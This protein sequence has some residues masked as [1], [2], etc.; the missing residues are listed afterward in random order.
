MGQEIIQH[1]R[2]EL[3]VGH[4]PRQVSRYMI[5]HLVAWPDAQ[6]LPDRRIDQE[7][8]VQRLRRDRQRSCLYMGQLNDIVDLNTHEISLLVDDPQELMRL[9]HIQRRHD[10]Q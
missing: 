1:L 5:V 7:W 3:L 10:F 8:Y 4:D 6:E 2:N 9:R